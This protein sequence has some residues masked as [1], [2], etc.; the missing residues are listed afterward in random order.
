MPSFQVA[1]LYAY[2]DYKEAY[3]EIVKWANVPEGW[4]YADYKTAQERYGKAVK[5]FDEL[6]FRGLLRGLT[7]GAAFPLEKV[8][9]AAAR[10]D[11]RF[12]PR[13]AASR[14]FVSMRPN[15]KASFRWRWRT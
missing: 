13:C 1:A 12:A 8:S 5:R 7:D 9:L 11:R 14:R 15:M 6:Y 3:E 2:R 10:V 4:K